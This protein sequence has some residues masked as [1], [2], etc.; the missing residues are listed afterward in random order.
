MIDTNQ[1]KTIINERKKI[2]PDDPSTKIKWQELI[3]VFTK[4]ED[5]TIHC[6]VN[7]DKEDIEWISEV[8][9]D[10]SE[11]L[12]SKKFIECIELLQKK[13]PELD[14]K[15]DVDFAKEAMK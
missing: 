9:E 14:L 10:I 13:Y 7:C 3:D 12:Q 2:H 4:N 15:T 1:V 11:K 6:L 8:F 5:D